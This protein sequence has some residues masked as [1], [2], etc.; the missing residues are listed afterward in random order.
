MPNSWATNRCLRSFDHKKIPKIEEFIL[1]ID[2]DEFLY[3]EG[4][5]EFNNL[6]KKLLQTTNRNS[7]KWTMVA[8]SSAINPSSY[9]FH[10]NI[11]K[12]LARTASIIGMPTVHRFNVSEIK[13]AGLNTNNQN[14]KVRLAHHWGRTFRDTLIKV[15]YQQKKLSNAKNSDF[16]CIDDFISRHELP[17]RFRY[18]A[19]LEE[20]TKNIDI[21]FTNHQDLYDLEEEEVLLSSHAKPAQI[22]RLYQIYQEYRQLISNRGQDYVRAC[23]G[24]MGSNDAC[25]KL[26]SLQDLANKKTDK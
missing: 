17:R 15:C 26:V 2:C 16:T 7:L 22:E 14:C 11:G 5:T 18:M 1:N 21:T 4:T 12:D 24:D 10:T 9:G 13:E 23:I 6:P 19:C 8:N 20:A 25:K 3:V